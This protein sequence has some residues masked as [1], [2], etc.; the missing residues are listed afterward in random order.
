MTD[1]ERNRLERRVETLINACNA[2]SQA[3]TK[4]KNNEKELKEVISQLIPFSIQAAYPK[5]A[6]GSDSGT[7]E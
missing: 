5:E 6:K 1:P 7:A 4:S 3:L 2:L